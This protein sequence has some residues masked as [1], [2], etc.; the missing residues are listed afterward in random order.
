MEGRGTRNTTSQGH[1]SF[2]VLRDF[3][4]LFALFTF[5]RCVRIWD[6]SWLREST[7]C[8]R[9][10]TAPTLRQREGALPTSAQKGGRK[11]LNL[12]VY[13]SPSPLNVALIACQ[14]C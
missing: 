13:F 4:K 14:L 8:F 6:N 2:F 7:Q 3:E 11:I 5:S 10:F 1:V 9:A 12:K